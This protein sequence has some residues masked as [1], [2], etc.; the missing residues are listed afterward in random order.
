MTSTLSFYQQHAEQ[1]SKQYQSVRFEDVHRSWKAFWPYSGDSVLDVGA[2]SGRDAKWMSGQGCEVIALEPSSEL[3]AKGMAYTGPDVTWISDSLP[4]LHRIEELGMRFDL[5]LV[6]AVWMHLA[7]S[8]RERA[9]RKLSNLLAPN[10]RLVISLRHG[11]F[12][13]SRQGYKVSVEELEQLSKNRALQLRHVDESEDSL[14]RQNVRWQTVVMSLPDDGA[15]DLNTVRHI[16]VNDSKSATYKLALFRTLL[17]ISD[18]H[19]GAVL[20]R[21][22]GKVV[23][24]MGLVALYWIR[25]FKRLIDIDIEGFGIQQ[26]SNSAKGLGFVKEDGWN[27]LKHL[28]A[29]DFGVGALFLGDDAKA[30]QKLFGHTINTI[31]AGP[32]QFIYQGSKDNKLFEIIPPSK[33]RKSTD[34]FLIDSDF[35]ASFGSF[36]LDESLWDC[37]KIYNSWIEPL[38]VNQ[39]VM[40]MRRFELNSKR[41][42]TLQTYHDCLVWIDSNHDTREVRQRVQKLKADHK[43]IC[44]VWSGKP[45][46]SSYHVDHCLPFA[47]WPNN[48]KWNLLPTTSQE[49]LRKSNRVPT[50]YRLQSSKSR[51][52]E[53]WELAWSDDANSKTRFFTE[54]SLSLPNIP[55]Q[56][57]DFEEVF[58]AMGLQIRGVKSRLLVSE[59]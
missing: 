13:D 32:V 1:L 7:P 5:I 26:N 42:I 35:L 58:D 44:S 54:A 38:V 19:S 31:K 30:I 3:K 21:S 16:I 40:E 17:R 49:N 6:S 4:Q 46:K 45:L 53:W 20:D 37:F 56:C 33:R 50:A 51:I 48:D 55:P 22:D 57:D 8:H 9:F 14:N 12:D 25:Q 24:P 18:A 27:Q 15:G 39:W 10:G 43:D 41:N 23:I 47:Y 2:G 11:E 36:V 59:W 34:S 28:T 29:D 52:I